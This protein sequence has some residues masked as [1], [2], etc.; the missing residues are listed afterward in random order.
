MLPVDNWPIKLIFNPTGFI[1]VP[2]LEM[3]PLD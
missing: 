2:Q 3:V 1:I